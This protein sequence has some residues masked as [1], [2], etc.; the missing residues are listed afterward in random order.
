MF[1]SGIGQG[2]D[3]GALN[4]LNF[5]CTGP[6]QR[7]G[8]QHGNVGLEMALDGHQAWNDFTETFNSWQVKTPWLMLSLVALALQLLSIEQTTLPSVLQVNH[9][10]PSSRRQPSHDA[11]PNHNVGGGEG[12]GSDAALQVSRTTALLPVLP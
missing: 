3:M 1:F 7:L 9:G 5:I 2:G 12:Q 11:A 6:G 10:L 4:I 8:A